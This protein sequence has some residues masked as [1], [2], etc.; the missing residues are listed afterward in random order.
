MGSNEAIKHQLQ[1]YKRKFYKDKAI[2]GSIYLLAIVL[3]SFL[4]INTIEFSGRL[5]NLGR[6]ILLYTF[7]GSILSLSYFL[8]IQHLLKLKNLHKHLSNE[9]AAIDIGRFF[10]DISDK[11]LNII[12][13]ERLSDSQNELLIASISQKSAEISNI[14]FSNAIDIKANRKYLRYA[15]IPASIISILLVV[16]PSF[17]TESSTRIVKY[18][19]D[20]IPEAPFSFQVSEASLKGFVNEAHTVE[21][22]IEGKLIP[23]SVN[24][25]LN[26]RRI[27]IRESSNGVYEYTFDR[28]SADQKFYFEAEGLSSTEYTISTIERPRVSLFNIEVKSPI[29]TSIPEEKVQNTGN[30][31]VAEG[32]KVTWN[33]ATNAASRAEL[34]FQNSNQKLVASKMNSDQWQSE[35]II[36]YSDNYS[37]NLFNDESR[38]KDSLQFKINVIKDQ[39]PKVSLE[40]LQDTVL[41]KSIVFAGNINDDYGFS[42][43]EI[44]YSYDGGESYQSS[45]IEINNRVNDQ[46]YYQVLDLDQSKL[47]AGAEIKYYVR[48]TDNDSFNGPKTSK[49]GTYT[50]KIPSI[51][52]IEADIEANTNKVKSSIDKTLKEAQ[53]LNK[54]IQE[55]DERLKSK[56]ELEWQDEKLMQEILEQKEKLAQRMEELQKENARNNEKQQQFNP[57]SEEIQQKME[58]LRE[59]MNNVLDEETRK[60]YEELQE[61]LNQESDIEEFREKMDE[62]NS[63]SE[64]LEQDL[65]RTLEL[66]KTL[67]F[68]AKLQQNIDQ[69]EKEIQDQE[70]LN[71]ETENGDQENEK[72]AE[73]QQKEIEDLERL[74][75]ELDKLNELNQER[76]NPDRLPDDAKDEL[77]EA[78][79]DQEKAKEELEKEESESEESGGEESEES[80][81]E[82]EENTEESKSQSG[83]NSKASKSQQRAA[84]KMKQVK[85]S[86]ESM[87]SS[88]EM[89]QQQENL[90]HLKDLVDNLVSLSYSQ[91]DLMN[92]F[93]ALGNADPRYVELSQ[94]QNKLKDDSQI[95]K[96]SLISLSERVFQI[97]SFVLKEVNEMERQMNGTIDVLKE[98]RVS[99]AV[100]KQQ[101][102]MT[103]INNLALLLDDVVQQMQQQMA[104]QNGQGKQGKNSGK[105]RPQA[106]GISE[107]Q[108]QLSEQISELKQS[109][110]SGRQLSEELAKLAAKQ[111]QLRNAMEQFE[112]G[113]NGQELGDKIE[114]LIQQMEENEWDLINKNI[115]QETIN[116]QQDI[117][118]RLLDAE[119]ALQQRGEDD[120]RKG[121]TAYNY[122]I[123]IP[124]SISEYL[125]AKEKEI[126]LLRTIPAK[127]NPYYKKETNKY[128]KRIK[129]QQ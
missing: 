58:Q 31:T 113:L 75:E 83:K 87:Q 103:S 98:K 54:K 51:E 15:V 86:L 40:Q 78:K 29:H 34:Y 108:K 82:E 80:K 69:L 111:E 10:P 73:Q 109:G 14:P 45:P 71:E 95:V 64:N 116:R 92:D 117:L 4:L 100:G 129:Q 79:E 85:E 44:R 43:L 61:L 84:Q 66:F 76:K 96:D 6:G 46:S 102:T 63:N 115:T 2:R 88:M 68:D 36:K 8:V 48:V 12:Q 62:L 49:T 21:L 106:G 26:N 13:L 70:A 24:I 23:S 74:Q 38:N 114:Q 123:S 107:L 28:L 118:T 37:I 11:L 9:Q 125:K 94:R 120:E 32:S 67:Q 110:K 55:A 57:Q 42:G 39:Y 93:K 124:E 20:F 19:E 99:E 33:I 112:T 89:E 104:Q 18:N 91:E 127:L 41:F 128:F 7:L 52:E 105:N 3:G 72:L 16:I 97:S 27:Q 25:V 22:I 119:N 59:I 121:N 50:F 122:D 56:K 1:S 30:I 60:L 101:F 90:E 17:I 5:N 47:T 53:E 126:E 35:L 65:E 81:S 77:E